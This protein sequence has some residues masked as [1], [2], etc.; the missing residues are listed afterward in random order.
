MSKGK[1]VV[2]RGWGVRE[3]G[4]E[5]EEGGGRRGREEK[6]RDVEEGNEGREERR[7]RIEGGTEERG[8]GK[9]N[10]ER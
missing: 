8:W 4:W 10:G 6:K 2:K 3:G 7:K 1:L 5:G 9:G